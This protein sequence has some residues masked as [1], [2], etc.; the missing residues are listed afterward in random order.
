MTRIVIDTIVLD[1]SGGG[2]AGEMGFEVEG[3]GEK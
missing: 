3:E 2:G 1:S